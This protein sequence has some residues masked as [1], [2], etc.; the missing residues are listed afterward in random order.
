MPAK[1]TFTMPDGAE[2]SIDDSAVG[3]IKG[4]RFLG[5]LARQEDLGFTDQRD[6]RLRHNNPSPERLEA[7][8]SVRGGK[9]RSFRDSFPFSL[10]GIEPKQNAGD[11]I[12]D[13]HR[14][15][16][17]GSGR[18]L[19]LARS[20]GL[21]ELSATFAV[22]SRGVLCRLRCRSGTTLRFLGSRGFRG[23]AG[24]GLL[25]FSGGDKPACRDLRAVADHRRAELDTAGSAG[26]LASGAATVPGC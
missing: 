20:L 11:L 2:A 19:P 12:D 9:R 16:W 25:R 23:C 22:A 1:P 18:R 5:R 4:R 6:R 7:K 24:L 15:S 26:P 14:A 10:L 17:N 3:Q 8:Q 13:S 21:V